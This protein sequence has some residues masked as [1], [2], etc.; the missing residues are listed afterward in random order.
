VQTKDMGFF[1]FFDFRIVVKRFIIIIILKSYSSSKFTFEIWWFFQVALGSLIQSNKF[2]ICVGI[3]TQKFSEDRSDIIGIS[4][5]ASIY[6][7]L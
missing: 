2:F 5:N 4:T 6:Q 1:G 3:S 7:N